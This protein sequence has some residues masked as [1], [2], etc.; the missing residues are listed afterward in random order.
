MEV[1]MKTRVLLAVALS[2]LVANICFGQAK[3]DGQFE[4]GVFVQGEP[5]ALPLGPPPEGAVFTQE[6]APGKGG[7]VTFAFVSSELSSGEKTVKAA[8]YSAEAVTETVQTLSDGNRITHKNTAQ[9]YR[10]GE[11]RT[12]RDQSL[13]GVGPWGSAQEPHEMIFIRD[14]VAGFHYVLNP[15]QHTVHKMPL[16]GSD[17]AT[18]TSAAGTSTRPARGVRRFD[19]ALG[20]IPAQDAQK[21]SL[22]KQV[23]EG[24][25]VEGTRST[26]TIEA[27]KMGNEL[28]IQI[29]SERWYSPE[30]QVVVMSKHTDPRMGET[31]YR[32][33]T[34]NRGEPAPSLFEIPADYKLEEGPGHPFFFSER[35]KKPAGQN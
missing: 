23:I 32:L 26:I 31:V 15:Q 7:D 1:L 29:V 21:E 33:T 5:L 28:P 10:D 30:L 12:R 25:Q 6:V 18:Q 11:G 27:G 20:P 34:I 4:A 9:V 3:S 17:T 22:G 8:P 13:G 2:A 35:K 24:I 16:P 19:H 14:P